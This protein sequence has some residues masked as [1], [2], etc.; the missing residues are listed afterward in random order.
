MDESKQAKARRG[1]FCMNRWIRLKGCKKLLSIGTAHRE[2]AGSSVGEDR[3]AQYK[4][5]EFGVE[6]SSGTWLMEWLMGVTIPH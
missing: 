2:P 4:E 5:S 3:Q 1:R 6:L